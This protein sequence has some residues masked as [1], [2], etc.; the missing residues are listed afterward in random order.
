VLEACNK[1]EILDVPFPKR[2]LAGAQRN[3]NNKFSHFEKGTSGDRTPVDTIPCAM[4]LGARQ[5]SA[6]T[7]FVT[8]Q[9]VDWVSMVKIRV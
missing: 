2:A 1:T 5:E 3:V 4:E 6:S 7:S 8:A 9:N